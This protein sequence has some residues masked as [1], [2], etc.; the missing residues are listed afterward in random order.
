[1]RSG[2]PPQARALVAARPATAQP[3]YVP[4]ASYAIGRLRL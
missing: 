2:L 1:M 4:D 3:Q